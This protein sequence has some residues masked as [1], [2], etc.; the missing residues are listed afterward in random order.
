MPV[1]LSFDNP[2]VREQFFSS[3]LLEKYQVSEDTLESSTDCLIN[4]PPEFEKAIVR[5]A[6]IQ[7]SAMDYKTCGGRTIGECEDY[8]NS[9]GAMCEYCQYFQS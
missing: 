5:E 7:Y 9:C 3:N 1:V 2:D 6:K 4:C 8:E